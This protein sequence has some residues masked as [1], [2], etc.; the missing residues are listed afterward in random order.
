MPFSLS[1]WTRSFFRT[2][3]LYAWRFGGP[4]PEV[5]AHPVIDLIAG[6]PERAREVYLGV[7]GFHAGR[8]DIG[9]QSPFSV[10][11]ASR[12][13]RAHLHGFEWLRHLSATND[14]LMSGNARALID[15]WVQL[16]GHDV[17][18]M[19]WRPEIAARRLNSFLRHAPMVLRNANHA[20]YRRFCSLI[21]RHVRFLR[22]VARSMPPGRARLSV[23]VS[24]MIAA[25]AVPLSAKRQKRYEHYLKRDLDAFVLPDGMVRT[26]NTD[27]AARL[28]L[29]LSSL[30]ALMATASYPVPDA[31][32]KALDRLFP[33]INTMRHVSGELAAFNGSGAMPVHHIA[34]LLNHDLTQGSLA[35]LDSHGH[36]R[37]LEAANCCVIA[38]VGAPPPAPF[39]AQ[40]MAGTTSFEMSSDGHRF[41]V[42]AGSDTQCDPDHIIMVRGTA[43]HSAA[44][45]NDQST[46]Q[47]KAYFGDH[48]DIVT[49]VTNSPSQIDD[50]AWNVDGWRG[51]Q[52]GHNGYAK[53]GYGYDRGV[54]L[55]A[56]GNTIEGFDRF[57]ANAKDKRQPDTLATLR[58]H[59][60]PAVTASVDKETGDVVIWPKKGAA[61]GW[62]F[63]VRK[64]K[65]NVEASV[66][67]DCEGGPR[68][69]KVIVVTFRPDDHDMIFWRFERKK[70]MH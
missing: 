38:D 66:R 42:N 2:G 3:P 61:V 53:L 6:N 59:L 36:Y 10:E 50:Q 44:V 5:I 41:I 17:R 47:F 23:N 29:D 63:A 1:T 15:D 12:G 37:R 35:A 46:A 11:G 57:T 54:R 39:D 21:A 26:R 64:A 60:D 28:A 27:D 45:L 24:L 34:A 68:Q 25:V 56:D 22:T 69:S 19:P 13:W 70:A 4:G 58:F 51:F 49:T 40:A 18:S 31:L 43:A 30:V 52:V 8:V 14:D 32:P 48:D 16:C 9:T 33:A 62:V 7:Y 20:F 67:F 65:A 55:S